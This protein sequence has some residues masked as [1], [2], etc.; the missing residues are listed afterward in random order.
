M[1]ADFNNHIDLHDLIFSETNNIDYNFREKISSTK[2]LVVTIV[3][4]D[5][6]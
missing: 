5:E 2:D 1:D 3:T 4:V 6:Y